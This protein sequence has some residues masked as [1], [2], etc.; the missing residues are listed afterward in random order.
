MPH[1]AS[2]D[3]RQVC[4]GELQRP[5]HRVR[6]LDPALEADFR[7]I[8]RPARRRHVVIEIVLLALLT[9]VIAPIDY[10]ENPNW[11][12]AWFLRFAVLIPIKAVAVRIALRA[13][14]DRTLDFA[15]ALSFC[16]GI[17]MMTPVGLFL[18]VEGR[19]RCFTVLGAVIVMH[20]AFSGQRIV[21]ASLTLAFALMVFGAACVLIEGGHL[22]GMITFAAFIAFFSVVALGVH[23][24][25]I[26]RS[27]RG[28]FLRERMHTATNARLSHLAGEL[29]RLAQTD[30]LTGIGNRRQLERALD[31]SW[32][33]GLQQG[34]WIGLALCDVDY[35]KPFNDRAGHPAGDDCLRRIAGC[36]DMAFAGPNV[37]V[38]RFGGE[39]F[40]IVASDHSPE[41]MVRLGEAACSAI[42]ALALPHPGRPDGPG[43]VTISV[44][45]SCFVP[46]PVMTQ[47]DLMRAADG[48]LY[49]A[50]R[51]GRNRVVARAVLPARPNLLT[52]SD[53]SDGRDAV[54]IRSAS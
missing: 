27:A 4:A 13:P 23:L 29:D 51:L 28:V 46:S 36:L 49:E 17:A 33:H 34:G 40:A 3:F 7:E 44:G 5:W 48:A 26:E 35:F 54:R 18:E 43:Q 24:Y 9:I 25:V 11:T 1:G 2:V 15:A 53:A 20:T 12:L 47:G 21:G 16:C 39:E 19:I 45:V 52:P 30:A 14:T 10:L 22:G 41:A 50:K 32:R 8:Q 38:A 42:T 6:F 31:E 37:T